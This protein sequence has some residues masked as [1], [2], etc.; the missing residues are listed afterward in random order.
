MVSE[1]GLLFKLDFGVFLI[2]LLVGLLAGLAGGFR[3]ATISERQEAIKAGVGR[4]LIEGE[5]GS[6][7]FVYGK[8][9]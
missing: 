4:Y 6:T 2:G 5:T 9:E 8:Q 1:N 3:A 7:R